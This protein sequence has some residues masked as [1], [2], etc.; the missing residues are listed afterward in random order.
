M[1]GTDERYNRFLSGDEDAIDE[2]IR[3]YKDGLIRYL[4]T[5]TGDFHKAEDFAIDT[6]VR[7]FT[8]K[9]VFKGDG[10]FKTWLYTIGR[11]IAYDD[12]RK[13]RNIELPIE[14]AYTLTDDDD[15]EQIH[16]ENE[17]KLILRNA[18]NRLSAEYS[19]ALYLF[20]FENMNQKEIGRI[21]NK[22][23]KQI[24][25]LIFRAKSAL[26]KELEKGGYVYDGL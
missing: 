6:F 16:T 15:I 23:Q 20:Y 9:P 21:M 24:K 25:N 5:L 14:N 2:I 22:S 1:T 26:K 3:D 12:L 11:N 8:D 17:E 19:Q 18:L 13:N 4:H 7:L 10:Q